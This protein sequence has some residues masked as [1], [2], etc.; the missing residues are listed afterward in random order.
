MQEVPVIDEMFSRLVSEGE[1]KVMFL[2][3][4]VAVRCHH[5]HQFMHMQLILEDKSSPGEHFYL[6]LQS[7]P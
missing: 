3:S 2:P 1:T 7:S 6:L 4:E 5:A